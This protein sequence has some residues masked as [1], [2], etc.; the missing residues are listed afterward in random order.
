MEPSTLESLTRANNTFKTPKKLK[1]GAILSPRHVPFTPQSQR[2]AL[3]KLEGL[4]ENAKEE[5]RGLYIQYG[6]QAMMADWNKLDAS[7]ELVQ[8]ELK[9]VSCGETQYRNT[10]SS[11]VEELQGA[12]NDIT[13]CIEQVAVTLGM[14]MDSPEKD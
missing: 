8:L 4:K 1:L 6:I 12:V 14:G 13:N 10:I 11:S 3:T 5:E 9:A 2:P 7:F